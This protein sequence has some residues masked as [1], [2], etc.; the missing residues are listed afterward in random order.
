MEEVAAPQKRFYRQ[1]AHANPLADRGLRHPPRPQD[2]DWAEL[3]PDFFPPAAPPG[4]PPPRVE[5]ADLGC[6]YGGLLVSLSPL[7]P[8]S[9][10]L[11][12]ELRAKVAA[13]AGQRLRALR[14]AQRGSFGNAAVL[15]ANAM[16]HLP[17]FFHKGQLSKL[18]FLFPDPHF[19]RPK[20]KW[21]IISPALLAQYGYVLRP[22]GL[23]YTVT[24]VP[25]LHEWM[26]TH[27]G[28][29]PLFEA[30][31]LDQLEDDPVAPLLAT[32]TEEGRKVQ[33]SGRPVFPAVFRR[34]QD[35]DPGG[36]L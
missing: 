13:F 2:M 17:H 31:P 7:F 4:Q 26:V 29:H 32:A 28:D 3:F 34:L 15:R 19:K 22:G 30:V 35:P 14:A 5:F 8:Q 16:K 33:R 11:G 36:A 21:R 9:L 23:V 10:M 27:F 6:G 12:L 18:F 1:R 25:E 24:D 20:H